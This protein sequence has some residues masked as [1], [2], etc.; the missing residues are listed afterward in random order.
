MAALYLHIPFRTPPSSS[1]TSEF[2]AAVVQEMNR[3]ARPPY[4]DA[5]FRAFYVGGGRPSSLPETALQTL[6]EAPRQQLGITEFDEVSIELHPADASMSFLETLH[7]LGLT[8]LSIAA[9]SFVDAELRAIEALY[10]TEDLEGILRTARAIG[11]ERLSVDL[12]FGGTEQSRSTWKNSLHNAVALRVPHITLHEREAEGNPKDED[13]RAD[14]FAFAMTFLDAKGYEQ[15]ELTHF[16]RPGHRSR[17]QE[18]VYAH[19]NVLGLGPGAE[20]FWWPDRAEPTSAQRWANV[21]DVATYVNQLRSDA[22]PVARR[23]HFDRSALAREYVLLR[24]RT[25]N[26]LDLDVLNDRYNASLRTHRLD[27]LIQEGLLHDDPHRVRLTPRGR[28]LAD[29]VT[30]RLLP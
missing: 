21:P 12:V 5:P 17:Y 26:G 16:A 29:A 15:Y 28:L 3:Y 10:S 4:T 19:S 6:V 24:L 14:R 20:S 1:E 27:R 13:D 9:R 8:R 30:Q 18:Q 23:E 22:W 2:T 25:R 7:E 11:V